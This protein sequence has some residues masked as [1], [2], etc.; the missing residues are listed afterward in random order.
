MLDTDIHNCTFFW[1]GGSTSIKVLIYVVFSIFI[2][3]SQEYR[4]TLPINYPLHYLHSYFDIYILFPRTSNI[5]QGLRQFKF[6]IL[7]M[8]NINCR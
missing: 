5:T 6:C 7:F 4:R 3:C 1:D 8:E 2:F